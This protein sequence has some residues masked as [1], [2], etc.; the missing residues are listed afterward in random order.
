MSAAVTIG[1]GPVDTAPAGTWGT[2]APAVATVSPSGVVTTLSP[3]D[4]TIFF[5]SAAGSRGTKRLTVVGDFNDAW[6]G[7]YVVSGCTESGDFASAGF[8]NTF[9]SGLSGPF[10][11]KMKQ[12]D[13]AITAQWLLSSST[14]GF[15][16]A[17]GFTADGAFGSNTSLS[18]S[19]LDQNFGTATAL[20]ISQTGVGRIDGTVE[21]TFS[22]TAMRGTGRFSGRITTSSRDLNPPTIPLLGSGATQ[23][24]TFSE[25]RT[26]L[27]LR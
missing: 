4:L 16:A 3:G 11:L 17:F 23:P 13:N 27:G 21:L 14:F 22:N 25:I 1:G 9:A 10:N 8:C 19:R 26:A 7:T 18:A 20:Q 2:D 15:T 5:D 24:R 12:V 6:S